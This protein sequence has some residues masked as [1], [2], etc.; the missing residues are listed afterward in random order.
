MLHPSQHTMSGHHRPTRETPFEWR[1]AG[2]PIVARFWMFTGIIYGTAHD[3]K[4]SNYTEFRTLSSNLRMVTRTSVLIIQS[5][6]GWRWRR[7]PK[8]RLLSPLDKCACTSAICTTQGERRL[9]NIRWSFSAEWC[10]IGSEYMYT[11]LFKSYEHFHL[12]TTDGHT[13]LLIRCL[14]IGLIL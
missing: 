7:R 5:K 8:L 1:F 10:T 3:K 2:G 12:L 6:K 4:M 11:M 14:I 13:H 9:I